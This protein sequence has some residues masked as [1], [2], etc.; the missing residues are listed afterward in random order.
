MLP[1]PLF[2]LL[3][4][5]DDGIQVFPVLEAELFAEQVAVLVG[6]DGDMF[7]IEAICLVFIPMRI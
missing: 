7:C 2:P 5:P 3:Q 4:T 1:W 6:R